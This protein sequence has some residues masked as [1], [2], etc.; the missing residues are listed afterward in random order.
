M[1]KQL[2]IT[3][4]LA[5]ANMVIETVREAGPQGAPETSIYLALQEHGCTQEQ[6][7]VF[8]ETLITLRKLK[9]V[10]HTLFIPTAAER[11]EIVALRGAYHLI[12][13][14]RDVATYR[15]LG[16]AQAGRDVEIRRLEAR[17]RRL[18]G[19]R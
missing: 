2:L 19:A 4:T 16:A 11:V 12:V 8:I 14:V 5:L 3:A 17:E 18:E 1:D 15:D 7:T 13:D 10:N 9:R 6:Y